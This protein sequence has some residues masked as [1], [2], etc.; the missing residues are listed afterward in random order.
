MSDMTFGWITQMVARG[1]ARMDTL[2]D[3]NRAFIERL[4]SAFNTLWFD[5][6]F[7]KDNAP[8]L[9]SWTALTYLAASYP[10][11]HFGTSVLA[12]GFRGPGLLAKMSAALQVLSGG[13]LILGIGAGWMESEYQAYGYPFPPARERLDQLE[14][15]AQVLKLMWRGSPVTFAGEHYQLQEAE[16]EPL[17][18]PPP[19]LLIGGGGEKRTLQIVARHADWMNVTFHTPEQY[20][21]KLEVLREHCEREGSEYESI[22][23]SAWVYIYLTE[24]GEAAAPISGDRYVLAGN[25]DQVAGA[26]EE[27]RRAGAQHLMLRFV[28]FP[29]MDGLD[30]FL[31][32]VAPRF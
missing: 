15:L 6:H 19:Q 16:C 14:E 29:R 13:R 28:D 18:D 31:K 2:L 25:P 9:E 22:T 30:L 26:L 12:A 11:Y 21:R 27:F 4:G 17:P 5:D 32:E 3:D 1:E 8:I 10:Q 20:A 7:H 23:K 24:K